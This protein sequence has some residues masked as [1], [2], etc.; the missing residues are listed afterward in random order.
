MA[1]QA[2]QANPVQVIWTAGGAGP[3]GLACEVDSC[4]GVVWWV[5]ESDTVV[6]VEVNPPDAHAPRIATRMGPES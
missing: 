1:E 4:R 5:N 6:R 3:K 2:D